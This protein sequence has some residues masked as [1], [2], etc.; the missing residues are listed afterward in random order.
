[1]HH[2]HL[3]VPFIITPLQLR[4]HLVSLLDPCNGITN[5]FVDNSLGALLLVH[6]S[7]RLTHQ[8]W[9]CVV[10]SIVINIITCKS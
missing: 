2:H 5:Q 3:L 10:H 9:S 7:G 4:D 6:N 8:E 1:M